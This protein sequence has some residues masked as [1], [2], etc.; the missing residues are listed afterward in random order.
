MSEG[1]FKIGQKIQIKDIIYGERIIDNRTGKTVPMPGYK[2]K[3][4]GV[5]VDMCLETNYGPLRIKCKNSDPKGYE[6]FNFYPHEG[7]FE[8]IEDQIDDLET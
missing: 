1:G 2:F 6:T 3:L 4:E 7:K 8:V 5:I